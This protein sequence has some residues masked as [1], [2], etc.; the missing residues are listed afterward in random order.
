MSLQLNSKTIIE[1]CGSLS[2]KR[3]EAFY[4]KNNI[5]FLT[6]QSTNWE[7][8]VKG[9]EE[10]HVTITKTSHNHFETSCTCPQ[11]ASIKQECQHV[12]AVLIA[13]S[14]RQQEH[15][16]TMSREGNHSLSE[17]FLTLFNQQKKR[18]SLGSQSHFETRQVLD[19]E[20]T[21]H[22]KCL[23]KEQIVLGVELTIEKRRIPT[24]QTFLT[25]IKE[26]RSYSLGS[27]FSFDLDLHCFD[28]ELEPLI[29]ELFKVVQDET[30][31]SEWGME[32]NR[33]QNDASLLILSPSSWER[34]FP[35][36]MSSQYVSFV[37]EN[38]AYSGLQILES[39]L[40]LE[41]Y[42]SKT[43][44]EDIILTIR[45]LDEVYVLND[46]HL[47]LFEGK[48]KPL[49]GYDGERLWSLKQMIAKSEHHQI[50][51]SQNQM[52]FLK[53]QVLPS[54]SRLG[55]VSGIEVLHPTYKKPNL[56]AK[57]YLDR[58]RQRLLAGLSFHYDE[59][60]I[61]PLV[62][63]SYQE[64]HLMIRDLQKE[65]Q[66]L[67]LMK[68]SQFTQTDGGYYLH[69]E[70]LEYEF[71]T[72]HLP[73][74]QNLVQVYAT[75]AV[76]NRV[77]SNTFHPQIRVRVK[78]ERTNWLEFKFKMDGISNND[79]RDIL[80]ALE[81]KRKFY[82]LPN[83]TLLSLESQSF[84]DIRQFLLKPQVTKE[85]L[86]SGLN[87]SMTSSLQI[88]ETVEAR[89][90]FKVDDSFKE[91][92]E[93]LK[94]PHLSPFNVPKALAGVLRSYQIQG[95]QW[96]KT[97][98]HYGFGGVLADDMGLGKTLQSITYILSEVAHLKE[99]K[100]RVLIVCPSSLTYNW[101][102]ELK[103]FAPAVS[104]L[105][106][107]GPQ[108]RRRALLKE[109]TT[110]VIVTSYPLLRSDVSW[111]EKETFHTIF[112]DEAQSFKNPL[113]QTA[114][115]VKRLKADH[116][117]ALTGTPLENALEELWAIF[118]V[119]FPELFLGLKEF[120]TLSKAEI[121]K[122]IHPFMLR[123]MK[124]DVLSELPEKSAMTDTV[125]LLPEQKKLYTAYLAKLRH[126]TLKHLDKETLHKNRIK[127]LAGLTRLRQIC[128]HPG[129]FI[130]G[131]NGRSAK[132]DYLMEL[133]EQAE[134]S[135][136]RVLI[137]SQFTTMLGIIR[138]ELTDRNK[139][140]FYLDGDTP[141]AERVRLCD[142]FNNGERNLFL[143]SLKAGGT[144]L[145]LTGADT[146]ILYDTWWNPAVEEQATDRA[147]RMGQKKDVQVIKLV[148]S[149]TI[150]E[151]MNELQDKKRQLI[152]EVIDSDSAKNATLTEADLKE[153]LNV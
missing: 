134:H 96:L 49:N 104:A 55:Q 94:S 119:V 65:N 153:L 101:L 5:E 19:F 7:A 141:S 50:L 23:S 38:K 135:G 99:T 58:V 72:K 62:D 59:H 63:H 114:R 56:K 42:F 112:F 3:G 45:G 146:V 31:F 32:Q 105:V 93:R 13:L 124:K 15:S 82:R 103:T 106:I 151:K 120:S 77:V 2:F 28:Q 140:F 16:I 86:L 139:T 34:L 128:C 44:D 148:C 137:F 83:D 133:L 1:R 71:L 48:L 11:L 80:T 29:Q 47:A 67:S 43:N 138:Q 52:T 64:T 68:E 123:R 143:I 89:S 22:A 85:D 18:R 75:T 20:L 54:L 73:K 46:Y 60:V 66:I 111:Y 10:F 57:L 26:G 76:R 145:N 51:L 109:H 149:G 30:S 21:C 4:Y 121:T 79:I 132:F 70:H 126:D 33:I 8:I 116:R 39:S 125:A 9:T 129:L 97:L 150:E 108:K 53:E 41:F 113:S 17:D 115:S 102:Q 122:R 27:D 90:I 88:L 12:A 127:I 100:R 74:L 14:H 152:E 147:H 25:A 118:H 136:R 24:I 107:D 130:D 110:D 92:L 37:C 117:F 81:E 61:D 87:L 144:G 78:K 35:I 131:Y 98:A 84:D 40:P 69:N 6:F 91:I 36:L 142:R 95:F